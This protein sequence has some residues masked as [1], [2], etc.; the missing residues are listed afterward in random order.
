[1]ILY[2]HDNTQRQDVS[3]IYQIVDLFFLTYEK[4]NK[5][6]GQR[7][8]QAFYNHFNLH[9]MNHGPEYDRLYE[10]D[11]QEAKKAIYDLFDIH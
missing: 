8:G 1:M 5:Y 3:Y 7:M 6:R 9:K 4:S 11:A 2:T 10:M